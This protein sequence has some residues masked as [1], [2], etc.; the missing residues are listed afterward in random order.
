MK[1]GVWK[2]IV[3]EALGRWETEKRERW[4]RQKRISC[5]RLIVETGEKGILSKEG[6]RGMRALIATTQLMVTRGCGGGA[7]G[8]EMCSEEEE[9]NTEHVVLRCKKWEVEREEALGR[10]RGRMGKGERWRKLTGEKKGREF[11]KKIQR[12][13]REELGVAWIPWVEGL[14]RNGAGDGVGRAIRKVAKWL[15]KEKQLG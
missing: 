7:E 3:R 5:Q 8:C 12:G 1:K 10:R 11:L 4:R 15:E 14:G 6:E 2:R 13:Y 9:G